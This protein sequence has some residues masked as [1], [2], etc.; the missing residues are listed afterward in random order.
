M[1]LPE[2]QVRECLAAAGELLSKR[3]PPPEIRDQLDIRAD[4]KGQEI[5]LFTVRPAYNDETRKVE[6]P[7]AKARWVGTQEV[8]K[9]YWMMSDLKWHSY[10]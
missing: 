5:I 7:F 4:I 10:H 8:W 6:H 2:A 1:A 9:L 3:R